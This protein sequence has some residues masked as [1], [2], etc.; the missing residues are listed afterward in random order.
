[1]NKTKKLLALV[2]ALVCIIA[3]AAFSSS[4]AEV[5]KIEVES[6][7]QL[8]DALM[9]YN[10][11][12][13]VEIKLTRDISR[14][15]D[16][17]EDFDYGLFAVA[18][19][20]TLDLNGRTITAEVT[21]G[22]ENAQYMGGNHFPYLFSFYYASSSLTI[23]DTS[24]AGTGKVHYDASLVK[25][26]NYIT[27]PICDIF[28]VSYGSL[29]IDGGTY[30]VGHVRTDWTTA[31]YING[32][33]FTGNLRTQVYGTVFTVGSN[34]NVTIN[35]GKFIARGGQLIDDK[36][37]DSSYVAN[38]FKKTST[39]NSYVTIN[40]GTF[41][42]KG[43]CDIFD[44]GTNYFGTTINNGVFLTEG[45][46]S[47]LFRY[48]GEDGG[49]LK[50]GDM[51]IR[52]AMLK[53][54]IEN[55]VIVNGG[56]NYMFSSTSSPQQ[57]YDNREDTAI[58]TFFD[59]KKQSPE[60]PTDRVTSVIDSVPLGTSR[61]IA[62]E[63]KALDTFYKALGFD[64]I[65]SFTIR[66][67]SNNVVATRG[68]LGLKQYNLS[69]ITSPGDY[70]I[71]VTL[72]LTYDGLVIDKRE[73]TFVVNIYNSC[74]H[75]YTTISNTATCTA[76]G[77]KTERCTKCGEE[78]T[79]TAASLGHTYG[80]YDWSYDG[81]S[82]WRYCYRCNRTVNEGI[83]GYRAGESVCVTCGYD[84]SCT[85]GDAMDTEY[86]ANYHWWP[87]DTHSLDE[88]CPNDHQLEKE[89]HTV[90][91]IENTGSL[92]HP[93]ETEYS[94][95]NGYVC[96][97][98]G[99]YFGTTGEH[100]WVS[101]PAREGGIRVA[102]CTTNG[103][104]KY[105]CEY[106]G[107]YD[108]KGNKITC[109]ATKTITI[110]ATG[111]SF[112]YDN[113]SSCTAT[114]TE[115]GYY[116]YTCTARACTATA[117]KPVSALGHIFNYWEVK[118]PATCETDG[119][120]EVA[121]IRTG[122]THKDTMTISATG[123]TFGM[124]ET[125]VAP[126]CA[127]NGLNVATCTAENCNATQEEVIPATGEHA[128]AD[129]V[130]KA[131]LTANGLIESKCSVCGD[132]KSSESIAKVNS[133]TLSVTNYVYDGKNK[134][135]KVTVKDA[136]GNQLVKNVDYKT[137]I[138]S[139]RSNI[140]KYYVKVTL[141][142]NYEGTK[143]VYFYIRPAG[144]EEVKATQSTTWI[145]LTWEKAEGAAGYVVYRY[146][147]ATDSYKKLKSTTALTYTDKELTAGTKYTYKVVPYGKSK[148]GNVYYSKTETIIGTATRTKTPTVTVTSSGTS[149]AVVK[150]NNVSGETGY[151][152]WYSTSKDGTYKRFGNA[153]A[154][155][156][157]LTVTGLTSGK[158][159]YIKVRTYTK[160]DSG[161]VYGSYSS[162]KSVTIPTA[163][164]S[165]TVT[166]S[167]KTK[168]L[169]KW[170]D[171]SG[172]NGYQVYYSTSKDGT[173]KRFGNAK[174]NATSLTVT[175]LTSGKTYYF[176]VR[177]YI[178]TDNGYVYSGYSSVKSVK[179]K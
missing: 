34:A 161:Y 19:N 170:D 130:T 127:N 37:K 97:G 4:A 54:G 39:T 175:G 107:K 29:T 15:F 26:K 122:C 145:K 1:M 79:S 131:T 92:E 55:K 172:E 80:T 148:T 6:W 5:E 45:I 100:K 63:E 44:D 81:S 124:A 178:N 115:D 7:S 67:S 18:G 86:D 141:M 106:D 72:D 35:G 111:H 110:P 95:Q 101:V 166:S 17:Y 57:F 53:P 75:T 128:Y 30:E 33:L 89:L 151:Q 171:V 134:T 152:V 13:P 96:D 3:V 105:K 104:I 153:K 64:T 150:W 162:I 179:V 167:S 61:V 168:A 69:S 42:G 52:S 138:A 120:S 47:V 135:P 144:L 117:M 149:K 93:A 94:C 71:T 169:V 129:A 83:H 102:T 159:Y 56:K 2:F 46:E 87:C 68:G 16:D 65:C 114:C 143:N 155:A 62:Y 84:D 88:R 74:S 10:D 126:D 38:V 51:H 21:I 99:E 49:S 160:T 22:E 73:H 132:V 164:P 177:T 121:C 27:S 112:D 108:C 90:C 12:D 48:G 156:T 77:T 78:K 98:C 137:S 176:K 142:G 109:S 40:G 41:Y 70:T 76:A 59:F 136:N 133:F 146:D 85:W 25:A 125:T 158:T 23:K 116:T 60:I 36:T 32:K 154:N 147:K 14:E 20:K 43:G 163:A 165:I 139:S 82:H 11:Y 9:A 103:Y 66:D 173:Y 58:F 24:A 28:G 113:P 8:R 91:T 119:V 50:K 123:H 174:A 31:V 140:G 157:S 118:T